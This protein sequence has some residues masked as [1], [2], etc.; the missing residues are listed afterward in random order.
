MELSVSPE[1]WQIPVVGWTVIEVTFSGQTYIT[2][3]G[4]KSE[5]EREAPTTVITLAGKFTFTDSSGSE[6]HLIGDGAWEPLT[7]LMSLRH[8]RITS[9]A[10]DRQSRLVVTFD[11]GAM[12]DIGS[13]E[14]YENWQLTAPDGILIVGLPGGNEPAVWAG[15]A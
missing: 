11:T 13:G 7:P 9:A 15:P 2:A 10:A 1:G 4:D 3:Y 5:G 14:H 8:S 6:H 12:L